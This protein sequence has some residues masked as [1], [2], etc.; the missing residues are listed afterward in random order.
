MS[1]LQ[2]I[3]NL[4]RRRADRRFHTRTVGTWASVPHHPVV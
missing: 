3:E 1:P 4:A 2:H